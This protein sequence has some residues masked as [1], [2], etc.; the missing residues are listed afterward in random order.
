MKLVEKLKEYDEKGNK[1]LIQTWK[2]HKIRTGIIVIIYTIIGFWFGAYLAEI[3]LN[4]DNIIL[5]IVGFIQ[6]IGTI[7]VFFE[8]IKTHNIAYS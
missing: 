7:L 5:I 4:Q 8:C 2:E 6:M 3:G 1:R